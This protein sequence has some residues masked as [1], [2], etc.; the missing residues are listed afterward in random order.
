MILLLWLRMK[1]KSFPSFIHFFGPDGSGKSTHVDILVGVLRERGI[2]AEKCW[3]RAHHTIAFVLWR[4]FVTI[5]FYRVVVNPFGIA[6]KIPAV[7][8]SRLLQFFWS[9][10]ELIGVIPLVLRVRYSLWMGRTMVAERYLLD[11]VTTI[12]YFLNDLN[13]L[14]SRTSRLLLRFLPKDAVFILLDSDYETIFQRRAPFFNTKATKSCKK[15][16]GAIPRSSVEPRVF[17]DFQRKAYELLAASFDTLMI[18][19]SKH[20]VEETSKAILQYLDLN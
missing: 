18:D 7:D 20:N 16:Y 1:S 14:Y 19:T 2:K 11:T 3:V 10:I 4:L 15:E 17:I 6:T 13:F 12:A 8:R 9:I 5:G